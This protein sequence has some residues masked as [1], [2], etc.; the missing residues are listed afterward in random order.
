MENLPIVL[1]ACILFPFLV[2]GVVI[3][4]KY[5]LGLKS[6]PKKDSEREA[7]FRM[8]LDRELALKKKGYQDNSDSSR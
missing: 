2:A 6:D 5:L 1:L 8:I 7:R 4:P 3:W